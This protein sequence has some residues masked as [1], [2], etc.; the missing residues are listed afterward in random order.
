MSLI[1]NTLSA[2]LGEG[3][4]NWQWSEHLHQASFRGVPFVIDKSASNFGRRQVVHSY[5]Y[6][7]TSYIEDM[8]RSARTL[9]LTGFL[10]QNSQIYTAPDVMT[11]RDSL[12]AACEMPGAGTLVHPTLGEMMVSV[13]DSALK[14]DENSANGRVFAF[15]LTVVESG[16][17]AFA[18]TGAAEM[19]ASIQSSWLG[20]SA[21]AVAGFISTVK[22][23]MR[24]ATQAIKTLKNTAAFWGRMVANTT[25][26]ASNL[27][28][29]LRSTLGR[30]RYGRFNHGTVGGSS[31]G[32]T[33]VVSQQS[34]T[35]NLPA[36]I[37]QRL[38][39]TVEGQAAIDAAIE[40]LL[41]ASSIDGY[42]GKV[43]ALVNALLA[44]GI[45]TLDI[46]RLMENLTAIRDDR[47]LA[48]SS[49]VAVM[50][51]S[52]HLMMTLCAGGMVSAAA[53]YQPESYDDAVAVLGRVCAV[54][55][56]TALAAADRGNDETYSALML[57]RES[58]V[59]LLQQAGANLSRIGEVSF[60]RSLP[61]LML[62]N[63]LYQDALRGDGLVKMANPIHPAFMPVRFKALN[64]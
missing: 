24:S 44:S 59:A 36:L 4:D 40:A 33:A 49:D 64:L 51:A 48:N 20:L 21:K 58:I 28:N 25:N 16:L 56:D 7:D 34:D 32:V 63:R 29:A 55:D 31:S 22:G 54:I 42:A 47:F 9:L 5:P 50:D 39:L 14:I 45:S 30:N 61:A 43:L 41:S 27:G 35:D 15:T 52:H 10:V 13:T 3:S 26:E 11:Q 37:A 17:R 12:I 23:E 62:A 19:G 60:N 1:G 38:A 46:I 8:G 6:R 18:I 53:Q 2:L 57:M